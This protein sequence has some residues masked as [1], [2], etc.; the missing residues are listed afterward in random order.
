MLIHD[1]LSGK[2]EDLEKVA[3]N[4]KLRL[5]VCGPT[6]Y[7]YI[8][9]GNAR[10]YIVFDNLVRYLR[11][12]GVKVFY[13]Q[14]I[15]DIDNKIIRRAAEENTNAK[16][17]AKKYEKYYHEDEK[18]LGIKSVT[19][20]ARA[21]AHIKQIV[22]QIQT[23]IAKGHA[24]KIDDGYYFDISTFPEYGKLAKRTVNQAEDS[25]SR[26]DEN[27]NKKNKGDFALWKFKKE[28]EPSWKTPI[29]EGRPGWHIEDTAITE[30]WFGP[31]YDIHGGAVDLKFPHHEAEIAQQE[32]A[33]GKKPMVKV[34]MHS[35]FL[36]VGGEKMSKSFGNFVTVKDFLKQYPVEVLRYLVAAHHYRSPLDYSEDLARQA[37]NTL[38]NL[39]QFLARLEMAGGKT[40][41]GAVLEKAERDFS[42]AMENDF[43]TPAALAVIFSL[44]NENQKQVWELSRKSAKMLKK[45]IK[46][47]LELF[48]IGLK[49]VK[50]PLKIRRLASKRELFRTNKQFIQS[51]VLRKE[52]EALGYIVEDTPRGPFLWPRE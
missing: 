20:Y 49:S 12:L 29:G 47:K 22:R 11:A 52:I 25:V 51:D 40:E 37:K 28:N 38:N 31:Q 50:I 30:R 21:T 14:N 17:L 10:T 7:D 9:I 42:A 5:F 45:F 34:W 16:S 13:L 35:G 43:N 18:A 39:S 48:G 15:T 1:T 41:N 36:V 23:L 32:A 8:H 4:K 2:K 6:V 27:V 44:I 3:D 26:I 24:Y 19:K 33:S 46:N